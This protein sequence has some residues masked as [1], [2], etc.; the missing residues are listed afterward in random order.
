MVDK[1]YD[2]KGKPII[3]GPSAMYNM[4]LC[5]VGMDDIDIQNV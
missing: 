4:R 1:I 5:L 2:L 3:G